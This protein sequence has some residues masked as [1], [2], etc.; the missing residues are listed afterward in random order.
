MNNAAESMPE[1]GSLRV[2]TSLDGQWV[3]VTVS[4][5]GRGIPENLLN[6]LFEPFFTTKAGGTGLGLAVSRKM[7]E[8]H[9]GQIGVETR[10]GEGTTFVVSLPLQCSSVRASGAGSTARCGARSRNRPNRDWKLSAFKVTRSTFS[11]GSNQCTALIGPLS[12]LAAIS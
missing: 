12:T 2:E 1:G 7:I 5:T 6:R 10:P 11:G 3:R 9:G 8:D 4:D